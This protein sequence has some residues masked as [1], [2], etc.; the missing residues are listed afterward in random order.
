MTEALSQN[1]KT[2]KFYSTRSDNLS[3][4]DTM[5][6]IHYDGT[7]RGRFG[8]PIITDK[9]TGKGIAIN[10]KMST[11]DIRK[12]NE[13]YPCQP[14]PNQSLQDEIK[15]LKEKVDYLNKGNRRLNNLY[16]KRGEKIKNLESELNGCKDKI[17]SLQS[18]LDQ[19]E[20]RNQDA[21]ICEK[22]LGLCRNKLNDEQNEKNQL[23]KRFQNIEKTVL[24]LEGENTKILFESFRNQTLHAK[25]IRVLTEENENLQN[26]LG[27]CQNGVDECANGTHK[28][29]QNAQCGNA[30]D[31]YTCTCNNGYRGKIAR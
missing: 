15:L 3:A 11:G 7:L 29:D 26:A 10:R 30:N 20:S 16:E 13:M 9:K 1:S 19:C 8:S 21:V 17:G 4:Y 23:E 2:K 5:S 24:Q 6:I 18:T 14:T 12:L 31:G 28:C 25:Q 22:E 27:T